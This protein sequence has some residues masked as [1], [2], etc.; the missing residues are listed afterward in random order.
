MVDDLHSGAAHHV[1]FNPNADQAQDLSGQAK[2]AFVAVI[3]VTV[4]LFG[5]M[6]M[7]LMRMER[8]ETERTK[9]H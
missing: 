8:E 5:I 1:D 9:G 6:S 4:I 7:R 3:I 2:I